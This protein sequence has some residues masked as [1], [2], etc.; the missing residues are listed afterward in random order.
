MLEL[1]QIKRCFS[2]LFSKNKITYSRKLQEK[3]NIFEK[4]IVNIYEYFEILKAK[5]DNQNEIRVKESVKTLP[6]I[7]HVSHL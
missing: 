5:N 2:A 7:I 6:K 3:E 1:W 4:Y